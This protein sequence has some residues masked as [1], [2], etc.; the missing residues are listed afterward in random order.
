MSTIYWCLWLFENGLDYAMEALCHGVLR[1]TRQLCTYHADVNIGADYTQPGEKYCSL[2]PL[3]NI[4]STDSRF[5]PS[6]WE[7]VILCNDVSHWLGAN[8]CSH[9]SLMPLQNKCGADS[10]FAPSQW[11]TAL[12]GWVQTWRQPKNVCVTPV[13]YMCMSI[14]QPPHDGISGKRDIFRECELYLIG[15]RNFKENIIK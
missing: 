2:M 10:R 8:I 13:P 1:S 7:T 12:I 14:T 3:H 9:C 5:A 4:C 15:Y 6:Q 11:E